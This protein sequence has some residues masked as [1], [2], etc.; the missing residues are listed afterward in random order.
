MADKDLIW[1]ECGRRTVFKTR[2]FS[3]GESDSVSPTGKKFT[4]SLIESRRWALTLPVLKGE[5]GDEF[6]MVRQWRHGAGELSV[7]FPGGVIEDNES[8][9]EGAARELRE[10]TGFIA[11]KWTLLATMNPNPAFMTNTISFLLAEDLRHDGNQKLDHDEFVDV[12]RAGVDEIIRDMGKPPYI[13]ALM[14]AGLNYF[15]R[16]RRV[17]V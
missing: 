7:E 13:H 9:E 1:K 3:V 17:R 14:A 10:E 12:L 11:G 16:E 5:K 8:I 4:Y 6:V 2:I 15:M